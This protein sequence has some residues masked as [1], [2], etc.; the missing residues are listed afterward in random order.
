MD[1]LQS[2]VSVLNQGFTDL[3]E[4]KQADTQ[5]NIIQRTLINQSLTL[6]VWGPDGGVTGSQKSPKILCPDCP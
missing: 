5:T 3:P 4:L 1:L 6:K 2:C